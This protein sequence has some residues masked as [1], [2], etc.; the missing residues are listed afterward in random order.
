M[1]E[2][3]ELLPKYGNNAQIAKNVHMDSSV[4]VTTRVN[5]CLKYLLLMTKSFAAER[6]GEEHRL[7]LS[8]MH[9]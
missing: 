1:K 4:E 7:F 8:V 9:A 5:Q 2:F 6:G 3:D